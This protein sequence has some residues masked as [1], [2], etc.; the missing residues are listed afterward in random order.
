MESKKKKEWIDR[1]DIY[2][3]GDEWSSSSLN[4]DRIIH[5][6]L[7]SDKPK[8][9][10]K[11]ILAQ[12]NKSGKLKIL[13]IGCGPG[14]FTIILASAG[15]ELTAVDGADGMLEKARKNMADYKINADIVQM[16]CLKMDFPDD[17][18]DMVVSRNVTHSLK[19]HVQ[20]YS[21]WKRVLKPGGVL[22]IYDANWHLTL[23][24]GP[25]R[26]EY[27]RDAVECIKRFGSDFTG[28]TDPEFSIEK[29]ELV[30]THILKDLHRPDWDMGILQ[31]LG[32]REISTERDITEEM[33]DEK[34]KLIYRTTPMFQIRAVK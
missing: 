32:Y 21:E 31:A 3:D 22:L 8:K 24:P 9:W 7:S 33:W 2:G 26:E 13:D 5:D 12:S 4:Y 19:D 23:Q 18:F 34:E 14:F 16:D 20:A 28:H 1:M 15:H 11:R 6:E 27:L 29:F 25:M 30:Q 10:Q 17:T